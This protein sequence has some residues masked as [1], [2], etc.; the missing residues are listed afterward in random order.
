MSVRR[1]LCQVLPS[2]LNHFTLIIRRKKVT[3]HEHEDVLVPAAMEGM[4]PAD[5][6]PNLRARFVAELAKGP[7]TPEADEIL[8]ERRFVCSHL[9]NSTCPCSVPFCRSPS[10]TGST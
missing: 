9:A 4:I 6:A 3:T 8:F 1:S 10:R 5:N 2:F 7:T